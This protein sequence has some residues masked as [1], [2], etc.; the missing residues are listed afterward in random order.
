MSTQP[1]PASGIR[2]YLNVLMV[3]VYAIVGT[4]VLLDLLFTGLP[5]FN[6]TIVGITLLLYSAYRLWKSMAYRRNSSTHPPAE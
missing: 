3:A 5:S 4:L 2:F 1:S 6:R